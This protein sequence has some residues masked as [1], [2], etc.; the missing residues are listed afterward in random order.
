M[1]SKR[2][3]ISRLFA[4]CRGYFLGLLMA[5]EDLEVQFRILVRRSVLTEPD[6]IPLLLYCRRLAGDLGM[7]AYRSASNNDRCRVRERAFDERVNESD[8]GTYLLL[9]D[10]VSVAIWC[11]RMAV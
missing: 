2:A 4:I 8:S 5:R 10:Q 3:S 6:L 1:P 7:I 9:A 11:E